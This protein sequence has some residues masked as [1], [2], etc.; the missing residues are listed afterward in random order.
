VTAGYRQKKKKR[1][2]ARE[3]RE[4]GKGEGKETE[5]VPLAMSNCRA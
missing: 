4:E 1:D 2:G 3:K 5:V